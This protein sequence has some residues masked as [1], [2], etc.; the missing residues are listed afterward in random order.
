MENILLTIDFPDDSFFEDNLNKAK[1]L[2][3]W[4]KKQWK[5]CDK[6]EIDC[7]D[8][9]DIIEEREKEYSNYIS[10]YSL[11]SLLDSKIERTENQQFD[12]TKIYVSENT[13]N[14]MKEH[15]LKLLLL[16]Y[17]DIYKK[18]KIESQLGML[19]LFS[20]FSVKEG[21]EDDRIYI[22]QDVLREKRDFE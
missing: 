14:K 9:I 10:I 19:H 4:I 17:K 13:Y 6:K 21:L 22:L 7:E 15:D 2:K 20:G 5:L 18:S 11:I 1:E 16:K 8:I 3:K 12:V